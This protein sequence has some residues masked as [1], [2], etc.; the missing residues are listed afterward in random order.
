M[1][2]VKILYVHV[3]E[4]DCTLG[5]S[6]SDVLMLVRVCRGSIVVNLPFGGGLTSVSPCWFELSDCPDCSDTKKRKTEEKEV[7]SQTDRC[8][9]NEMGTGAF[10]HS[11][12]RVQR[13]MGLRLKMDAYFRSGWKSVIKWF[14][15]L[16][17]YWEKITF[18]KT[19]VE[20]PLVLSL[21]PRCRH[22]VSLSAGLSV[23]SPNTQN[24]YTRCSLGKQVP[25]MP[26]LPPG[27]VHFCSIEA[28]SRV[29]LTFLSLFCLRL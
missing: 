14:I 24:P 23:T 2:N 20:S 27:G 5:T 8:L 7:V 11:F 22:T 16:F 26:C 19:D 18:P 29:R 25:R 4:R 10:I 17:S 9:E 28:A 13:G 6:G 21:T 1:G 15:C 3:C 12:R